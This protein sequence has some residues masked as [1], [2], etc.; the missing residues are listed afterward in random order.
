MAN[1]APLSFV[2]DATT[3][4]KEVRTA[5]ALLVNSVGA[6]PAQPQEMSRRFSLDKTLTWMITR[7]LCEDDALTAAAHVPGR[8]RV[9]TFVDALERA[10]AAPAR[11]EGVRRAME[12][13]ERLVDVHS[14]DRDTFDIM[15]GGVSEQLAQRKSQAFRKL[16][17]QGNSAIWGIQAKA[18]V[19][20][21]FVAPNDNPDMLDLAVICGLVDFRRLREDVPWALASRVSFTDDGQALPE[22]HPCAMY[23][24]LGPNDV[25][26]LPQFCSDA[27]PSIRAVRNGARTRYEFTEG[28]IGHTAATSCFLGWISRALFSRYAAP[29][30]HYGEHIVNLVTPTELVYHDL[31]IHRSLSFAIPPSV[32]IYSA[33]PG[34]PVYPHDGRSSAVIPV[35]ER[36]I[37]LGAS[38]PETTVASLP[39]F[40]E[41]VAYGAERMGW[42]LH[43]FHGFRF[44]VHY[45]PIPSQAIY[46]Y[47]LPERPSAGGIGG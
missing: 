12:R 29:D 21:H 31:Y 34:G 30:D 1:K 35:S 46:R 24:G 26:M 41:M 47:E 23:P 43:D 27:Q 2:E 10:G 9:R 45:P 17:Y 39:R 15:L 22:S 13:F 40:S 33:M 8:A 16:S 11:V 20:I 19:S 32:R 36:I 25:P 28:P 42:T 44:R 7:V 18:Q 38:P 3:V 5:L 6:D 4:L 14:G 37:D